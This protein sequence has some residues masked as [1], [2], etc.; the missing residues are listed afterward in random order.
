MKYHY[1]TGLKL[2]LIL[3]DDLIRPTELFLAPYERGVAWFT[4]RLTYEPTA[5]KTCDNGKT[6]LSLT[7]LAELGDGLYRFG[8]PDDHPQH[9]QLFPWL[10]ICRV[11]HTPKTVRCS[12]ERIAREQGGD[13]Y[14]YWGSLSPVSILG[15]TIEKSLD[16]DSWECALPQEQAAV[17]KAGR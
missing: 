7:E 6:Q 10:K 8:V 1:T 13:P 3:K 14:T 16:G 4:T 2:T 11:A 15:C 17:A 5:I 9:A 12:L